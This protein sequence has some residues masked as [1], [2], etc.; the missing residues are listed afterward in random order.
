MATILGTCVAIIATGISILFFLYHRRNAQTRAL[1]E[2]P[3]LPYWIPFVGNA[4]WYGR[5]SNE[6]YL[7]AR[8]VELLLRTMA[9]V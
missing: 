3:L 2:P 9:L 4:L 6:V 7:A 8:Y 1:N 5:R